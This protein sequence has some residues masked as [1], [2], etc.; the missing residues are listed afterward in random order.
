M[1]QR[2][3]NSK[4]TL[5]FY[6]DYYVFSDKVGVTNDVHK[7]RS[8]W[9]VIERVYQY[10]LNF[11][12]QE[13]T[14]GTFTSFFCGTSLILME[15]NKD[16]TKG[17]MALINVPSALTHFFFPL[18]VDVFSNEAMLVLEKGTKQIPDNDSDGTF[19]LSKEPPMMIL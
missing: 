14:D 5:S 17:S 15:L 3:P 19:V 11:F 8:N 2:K 13:T 10:D 16:E 6:I 4:K 9:N 1:L 7:I 12:S 18:M